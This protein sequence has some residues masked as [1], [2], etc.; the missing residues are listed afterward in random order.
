VGYRLEAAREGSLKRVSKGGGK[1][2]DNGIGNP[3]I[4]GVN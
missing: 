3:A 2:F 4:G 1:L